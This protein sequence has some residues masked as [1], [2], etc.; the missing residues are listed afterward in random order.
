MVKSFKWYIV[1]DGPKLYDGVA[2]A[3]EQEA[4][5]IVRAKGLDADVVLK[6]TLEAT[7]LI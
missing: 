7:G 1:I 3:T 6:E 2:Y 5:N 4:W